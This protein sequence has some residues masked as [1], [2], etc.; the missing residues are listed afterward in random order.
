ILPF[1]VFKHY[2]F[3]MAEG[4]NTNPSADLLE[5]MLKQGDMEFFPKLRKRVDRFIDV[6]NHQVTQRK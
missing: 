1:V 6:F 2:H 4:N 5:E 3:N